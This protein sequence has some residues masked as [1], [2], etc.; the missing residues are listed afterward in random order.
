MKKNR[1]IEALPLDAS[2]LLFFGDPTVL[3][4]SLTVAA[5]RGFLT[6]RQCGTSEFGG[7]FPEHMTG[8][9]FEAKMPQWNLREWIKPQ[10]EYP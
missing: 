4:R 6:F 8:L 10:Q 2:I 5:L 1:S 3:A 7:F 9:F